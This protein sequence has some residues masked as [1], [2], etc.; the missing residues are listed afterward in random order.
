MD[1]QQMA[2][3]KGLNYLIIEVVEK[4][5]IK[6]QFRLKLHEFENQRLNRKRLYWKHQL[7]N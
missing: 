2:K 1:L 4:K 3:F 7:K 5:R 6:R